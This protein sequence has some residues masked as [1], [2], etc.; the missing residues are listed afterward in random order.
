MAIKKVKEAAAINY[1][2]SR[3]ITVKFNLNL[4]KQK[5]D[6]KNVLIDYNMSPQIKLDSVGSLIIISV[7]IRAAINETKEEVLSIETLF[8]YKAE[9]LNNYIT[10][11]KEKG[12]KFKDKRHLGLLTTLIGISIS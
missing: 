10:E 7:Q 2:L 8:F 9:N 1:G 6:P 11:D 12:W 5:Y 3:V 4:P